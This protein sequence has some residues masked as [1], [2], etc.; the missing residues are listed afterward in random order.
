MEVLEAP[1]LASPVSEVRAL[2]ADQ[3]LATVTTSAGAVSL[4]LYAV[5]AVALVRF[6]SQGVR[7][8]GPWA[9]LALVGGIAGPAVAAA[10]LVATAILTADGGLSDDRVADLFAFSQRVRIVSGVFVAMFLGGVGVAALRSRGLPRW[11]AW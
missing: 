5:F 2:F 7:P 10:S 11:L 6:L 8:G 9:A 1:T 4:V 3:A